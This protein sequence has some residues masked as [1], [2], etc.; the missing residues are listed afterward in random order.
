MNDLLQF[1]GWTFISSLA[2]LVLAIG[3][4]LCLMVASN[5]NPGVMNDM[6]TLIAIGA[7]RASWLRWGMILDVLGYYLL[8]APL[9]LYLRQWLRPRSPNLVD[10]FTLSGFGYML[11]GAMGAIILSAVLPPLVAAYTQT[12][13]QARGMLQVVFNAFINAVYLGLW[14]PLEVFLFGVWLTGM[15]PLIQAEHRRLGIA[16][17][18]FGFCALMAALGRILEINLLF[19]PGVM[20]MLMFPFWLPA[21]VLVTMRGPSKEQAEAA[22]VVGT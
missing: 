2:A 11:V 10:L 21:F 17:R 16:P 12:P 14:N 3:S 15:G 6:S 19:L 18:F 13:A 22:R 8:L 7:A 4:D 9:A 5:A 1:R 20:G